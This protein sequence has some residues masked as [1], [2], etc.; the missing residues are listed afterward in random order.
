M[1]YRASTIAADIT[2]SWYVK[3]RRYP[4]Y[5]YPGTSLNHF[6][7]PE[8]EILW[9]HHPGSLQWSCDTSCI[10][11]S[12]KILLK[13]KIQNRQLKPKFLHFISPGSRTGSPA[14]GPRWFL[15]GWLNILTCPVE[16]IIFCTE[17]HSQ[18]EAF[19]NILNLLN[20]RY[21]LTPPMPLF[22]L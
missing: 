4:T 21:W 18:W 10:C 22:L 15:P 20:E 1:H 12:C 9:Y 3:N 13:P 19:Y 5:H 17:S 6:K 14:F 2:D 8:K 7:L 16:M 11:S